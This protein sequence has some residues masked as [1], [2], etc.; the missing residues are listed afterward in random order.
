MF[1]RWDTERD[2]VAFA[3]LLQTRVGGRWMN[4]R[5]F[6]CSHEGKNDEHRYSR[7]GLKGQAQNFHNGRVSEAF[8]DAI[9]LIRSEHE[10]MIREWRQ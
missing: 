9:G 4:V 10:R 8:R 6:D 5:L 2:V 7:E 1:V 3:V